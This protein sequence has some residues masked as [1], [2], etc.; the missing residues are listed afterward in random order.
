MP[1]MSRS[2]MP[3]ESRAPIQLKMN[4]SG[5]NAL[6]A[7]LRAG[8]FLLL[9]EQNTP[10]REQPFDS[11]MATAVAVARRL[12]G[13]E[14]VVGLAVTDRLRTEDTHDPVDT[15]SLL[16]E[17]AGKPCLLTLSGKGS[18]RDRLRDCLARAASRGLR[19]VLAVSGDRSDRHVL[20]RGPTG[21]VAPYPGGY[22]DSVATLHLIRGSTTG[23][24]AGAGINPFK[25]A[26]ADQFL[27]YYK[28]VRKLNS[29]AEF[30]VTHLGWDMKKLQELQWYLQMREISHPVLA[31]VPLL[32]PADIAGI[33][34]NPV[35]GVQ[36]ARLFY[37]MLQR[38]SSLSAAQCMAA[39]LHRIGLQVAGC[40]LLGYNGVQLVG[41]RDVK[42]LDMVLARIEEDLGRYR[43][44]A[45][46][47]Q[48][49]GE[50]HNYIDFAPRTDA[51]YLFQRLLDPEQPHYSAAVAQPGAQP[52]PRAR[53]ADRLR[54]FTLKWAMHAG[55]PPQIGKA[56]RFLT[57]RGECR[58]RDCGLRGCLFLC[59]RDCPKNLPWGACGGSAPDGTC[60]FGHAP[61]FYH[62][63]LALGARRHE[64]D[65]LEE[66][67]PGD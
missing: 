1:F 59:P 32:S 18:S 65:R 54:A 47:V 37:A 41:L 12:A 26:A 21:R 38:E 45:E 42:T 22:H 9:V 48:A 62:R 16:A 4:F 53:G 52:W 61:C 63:V 31:R 11:A 2:E 17:H 60:E 27:Q 46:W 30:L 43:T 15:A 57:C 29:G 20:K 39:Q 64:L 25:Y 8:Q 35:P 34:E 58:G 36:A 23:L 3:P 49:W 50:F 56:A 6:A 10:P 7:A 13:L 40:K 14:A 51:F 19:N 28:M 66:G 67:L 55:V 33:H 44:Y 5:E 24:F